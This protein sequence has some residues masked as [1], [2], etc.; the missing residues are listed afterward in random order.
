MLSAKFLHI[1]AL[2]LG[3]C[4]WLEPADSSACANGLCLHRF[5]RSLPLG[6]TVGSVCVGR[7]SFCGRGLQTAVGELMGCV[8]LIPA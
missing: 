8:C 4:D 6:C 7:C 1:D 5:W 2:F 3:L